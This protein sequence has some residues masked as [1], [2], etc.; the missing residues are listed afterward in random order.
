MA[1]KHSEPNYYTVKLKRC[2]W[3]L[4]HYGY[5]ELNYSYP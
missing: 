1:G 2:L 3:F 4:I 5:L